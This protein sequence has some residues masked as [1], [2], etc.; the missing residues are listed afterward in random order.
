[1][2][3]DNATD[4]VRYYNKTESRV[5]YDLFLHGTKHFGFYRPGDSPWKWQPALR[6]MEDKLAQELALPAGAHALDAG[7]GVADVASRLASAHGL[8]IAGIDILDFNIEEARK[9]I[10]RRRLDGRVSVFNMN[11]AAL[12]FSG[13]SFD[14]V[15]TLETLVHAADAEAVLAEF[16]RVLRPGGHLTLFEYSRDPEGD[17]SSQA[18]EAFR[19]VNEYAAMPSFQ[20]FE[21][22]LLERLL[23]KTGFDSVTVEDVTVNI[24]PMVRCFSLLGAIPYGAARALNRPEKAVNAMSAVEFWRYRQHFRYN[25]YTARK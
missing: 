21:H 24:L 12:M 13:E 11:Y 17:M 1:M 6:R 15:Y 14:G 7:C 25:I 8:N 20:R 3:K 10:K 23:E 4:V 16:Y 22:G 19:F 9:R 18:A 5:G 2:T